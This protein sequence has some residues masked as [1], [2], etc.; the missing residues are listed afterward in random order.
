[1][2]TILTPAVFLGIV[3]ALLAV[4]GAFVFSRAGQSFEDDTDTMPDLIEKVSFSLGV[5]TILLLNQYRSR[6]IENQPID[7]DRLLPGSGKTHTLEAIVSVARQRSNIP[8][9][10]DQVGDIF[11]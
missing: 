2:L 8:S 5:F 7:N 1:M 6:M 3:L 10:I 9:V 4:V 11:S